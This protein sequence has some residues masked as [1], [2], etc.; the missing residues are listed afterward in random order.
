MSEIYILILYICM[1][2]AWDGCSSGLME[3]RIE[4]IPTQQQCEIILSTMK[5]DKALRV[6]SGICV[7]QI[8]KNNNLTPQL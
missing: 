1:P 8:T 6:K 3:S 7:P 5:K 2:G 4:N